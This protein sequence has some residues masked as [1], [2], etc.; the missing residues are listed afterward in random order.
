MGQF[1][2]SSNE[3]VKISVP[4]AQNGDK[5]VI[6]VA[7]QVG[8][9]DG[10]A[11]YNDGFPPITRIDILAGGI[12]PFGTDFNGILYAITNMLRWQNSG[13]VPKFD[14][15]F[16]A[17]IGGYP[18]GAVL[19]K[20]TGI[21]WWI[22]TVENNTSNPD[23]ASPAGWVDAFAGVLSGLGTMSAQNANSVAITGGSI[24]GITDL[25]IADGGTGASTKEQALANLGGAPLASPALTGT[26]TAPTAGVG[27]NNTQIANTAFMQAGI[28]AL[29][30]GASGDLAATPAG[31]AAVL[32]GAMMTYAVGSGSANAHT[33]T[34]TPA[35]STLVDGMLLR[36]RASSANT[37]AATFSPN[38]LA[39]KPIV[40]RDLSVLTGGEIST[41]RDVWLQ[42]NAAIDSWVMVSAGQSVL[43]SLRI[44]VASAA[45][46]D[47]NSAAPNTRHINITGTTAIS[48]FTV[49]AGRCYFVRFAGALTLTNSAMLATQTG[50]DIVTK[51]GDTCIIRATAENTVEILC[52]RTS[53]PIFSKE[54]VSSA[55]A[56]TAGAV[57]TL[58][59]NFGVRAR[60]VTY[61]LKCITAE[62][63]YSVGDELDLSTMWMYPGTGASSGFQTIM[64]DTNTI[65]V[66]LGADAYYITNGGSGSVVRV[67]LNTA[68]WNLI[69]RAW[70]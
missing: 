31:L 69:V 7:S 24:S 14:S 13:G 60:L 33:A 49:S 65:R 66:K 67:N 52:F 47:L 2:Q 51:V 32:Q 56:M 48:A 12:P 15:A 10:R 45:T 17:S 18:K 6:P 44:D 70:A 8:V 53:Q 26:P 62:A 57:Y 35:V 21:G 1:M 39:A 4:F 5:Q 30:S 25:A 3:P 19:Q 28:A 16:S 11:S 58:S 46:V 23:G 27:T 9:A 54:Y 38:G 43:D 40:K 34:Y 64:Q 36:F 37:G 22:S 68:N 61:T 29:I 20:A 42:W 41:G 50:A 63:G 59:H 55:L